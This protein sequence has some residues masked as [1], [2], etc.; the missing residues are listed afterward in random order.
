VQRFVPCPHAIGE[1][2]EVTRAISARRGVTGAVVECGCF[3]GGSTA[4]LSLICK[5]LGRRLVVFDSFEG[6]P[7]PEDWDADHQIARKRRFSRGEYRGGVDEVIAN[8]AA[9]GSSSVCEFVPGWFS[10]TMKNRTPDQVAVAFVDA[11]LVASTR[12]ALESLW[13]RL[14]SGG[15]VYVHDAADAKLAAF[16]ADW[17]SLVRPAR[18]GASS[19]LAWFEK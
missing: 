9:Y 4:R 16:L 5:E 10:T 15:I 2:A 7:E 19:Q 1:L 14:S 12:D 3:K 11:D 18:S 17:A 6:L 13:P 8:V